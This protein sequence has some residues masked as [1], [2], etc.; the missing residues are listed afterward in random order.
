ME[1]VQDL[2]S[3]NTAPSS[4]TFRDERLWC[5]R[6]KMLRRIF[7]RKRGTDRRLGKTSQ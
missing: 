7:G 2:K 1:K 5:L 3:S 4:K 6:N